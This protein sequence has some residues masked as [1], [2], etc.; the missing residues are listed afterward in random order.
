MLEIVKQ[1][2]LANEQKTHYDIMLATPLTVEVNARRIFGARAYDPNAEFIGYK[3]VESKGKAKMTK[4]I[5]SNDVQYID[6]IGKDVSLP[7]MTFNSGIRITKQDL[8][9]SLMMLKNTNIQFDPLK[10]SLEFARKQNF[11]K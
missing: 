9:K 7:V 2:L 1:G 4:N 10:T 6:Q 3:T 8:E 5:S 11:R